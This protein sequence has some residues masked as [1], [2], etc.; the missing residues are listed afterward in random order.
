VDCG[1]EKTLVL[2]E[3]CYNDCNIGG[4]TVRT[5]ATAPTTTQIVDNLGANTGIYAAGFD[6]GDEGSGV[7]ELLHDYKEGTN[8]TF[9]IHWGANDAPSGT[10]Y[11][12]WKLTYSVARS[13]STFPPVASLEVETAHSV[14]YD[15][16]LSSFSAITG[17]N[18]KI[19]DQLNFTIKRITPSDHPSDGFAGR[20]LAQT[21]GYHYQVDT[22]G[23][24]KISTK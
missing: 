11:V 6:V 20:A 21:I 1:T 19:G 24:R 15:T 18:F 13:G 8:I 2:A 7:L 5:G 23:S 16:H 14:R 22:L 4:L 10:D 12:R 17:T 9:H 3:P